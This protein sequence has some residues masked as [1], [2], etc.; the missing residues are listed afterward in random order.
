MGLP[1]SHL[2]PWHSS[3]KQW[4]L[5]ETPVAR[6]QVMVREYKPGTISIASL[7]VCLPEQA[8]KGIRTA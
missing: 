6:E 5:G 2:L 4:Q 7:I 8:L 1:V 3:E